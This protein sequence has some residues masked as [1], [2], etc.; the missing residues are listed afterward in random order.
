MHSNS[1]RLYKKKGDFHVDIQKQFKVAYNITQAS[2]RV[3]LEMANKEYFSLTS[4]R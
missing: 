1:M 2:M 3:L 4:R